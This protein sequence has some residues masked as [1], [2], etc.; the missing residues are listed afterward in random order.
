MVDP[1]TIAGAIA[2]ILCAIFEGGHVLRKI[3]VKLKSTFGSKAGSRCM[4][5]LVYLNPGLI[6]IAYLQNLPETVLS[7]ALE[8]ILRKDSLLLSKAQQYYS[9]RQPHRVVRSVRPYD[10]N[11]DLDDLSDLSD[12]SDI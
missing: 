8:D 10:D 9:T 5:S 6:C 12:I 7:I 2:G 3:L 1:F 11:C 4:L